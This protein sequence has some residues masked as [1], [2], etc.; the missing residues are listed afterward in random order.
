MMMMSITYYDA[1]TW[2]THLLHLHAA[3]S[4]ATNYHPIHPIKR[5]LLNLPNV[6]HTPLHMSLDILFN[7][8]RGFWFTISYFTYC[9]VWWRFNLILTSQVTEATYGREYQLQAMMDTPSEKYGL[10][11]SFHLWANYKLTIE[12]N[13]WEWRWVFIKC[14]I[15]NWPRR[16]LG[17]D[18]HRIFIFNIYSGNQQINF[19]GEELLCLQWQKQFSATSQRQRVIIISQ[20]FIHFC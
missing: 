14:Q 2:I 13:Q 5:N 12:A 15:V 4:F 3:C 20:R 11:V 17:T 10:R 6:E 19:S 16:P 9:L 1:N 8:L 18:T 7:L